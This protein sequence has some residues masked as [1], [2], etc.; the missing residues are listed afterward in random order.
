MLPGD[1]RLVVDDLRVGEHLLRIQ[2]WSGRYILGNQASQSISD[3]HLGKSC[4]QH[5]AEELEVLGRGD[6]R[7]SGKP[8]VVAPLG[9]AG[10][11][12]KA[13]EVPVGGGKV[14][15]LA[16]EAVGKAIELGQGYPGTH[17][18]SDVGDVHHPVGPKEVEQGVQHRQLDVLA[19]ATAFTHQ[20]CSGDRLGGGQRRAL[21]GDDVA[22]QVGEGNLRIDLARHHSGDPL[23]HRVEHR[24]VGVR[25]GRPV[26]ADRD[27]DDVWV[28]RPYVLITDTET[29]AG[30]RTEVLE[31]NI[32]PGG[33]LE[34]RPAALL[35][36]KV[37]GQ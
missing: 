26:A 14:D 29:V 10:R 37:D 18:V 24:P 30:P 13:P 36:L 33:Q 35:G 6:Q 11:T 27:V 32:G 2:Y 7:V 12:V 3:R 19:T 17:V 23:D 34:H 16:V 9:V 28:Y 4:G 25:A 1:Q 5:G 31:D 20:E 15:D 8:F 21:V 22:Y